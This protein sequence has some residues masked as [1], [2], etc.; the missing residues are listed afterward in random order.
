MHPMTFKDFIEAQSSTRKPKGLLKASESALS[1]SENRVPAQSK[2]IVG[3]SAHR[4]NNFKTYQ[5]QQFLKTNQGHM[6]SE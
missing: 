3:T 4:S 5:N 2:S 6:S 1:S